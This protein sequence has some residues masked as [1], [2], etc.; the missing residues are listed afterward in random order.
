MIVYLCRIDVFLVKLSAGLSVP[1]RLY[2]GKSLL[3][4]IKHLIFSLE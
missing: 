2:P 4:E 1:K 3:Q